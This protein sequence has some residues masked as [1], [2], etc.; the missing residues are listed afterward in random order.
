MDFVLAFCSYKMC[1]GVTM[2]MA[3]VMLFLIELT[4]MFVDH[5]QTYGLQTLNNRTSM[6][7]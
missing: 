1:H 5:V 2:V 3:N 4:V 7:S 6:R